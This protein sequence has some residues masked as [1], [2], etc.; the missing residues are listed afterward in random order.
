MRMLLLSRYDRLGASSRV[1]MFQYMPYLAA[2]G[3]TIDK[4]PLFSDAY[5]TALYA[6]GSR[7]AP[8]MRGYAR[9]LRALLR[10]RA[11]NLLWIEKELFPFLPPW[12]EHLLQRCGV[13]YVVD[14]DDAVF[15][16][17]DLHRLGLVRAALGHKIDR[18]MRDATVV[19]AGNEYL[20]ARARSAG[21]KRVEIVPTVVDL[22]RYTVPRRDAGTRMT[23]G[24]IGSPSTTRYLAACV[25]ALEAARQ[26]HDFRV[27]AVGANPDVLPGRLIETQPWSEETEVAAIQGFDVGIMPLPD[28]PWER[29][30]CGYKLIQ[31]MA[32]GVPVVA[33]PVGVNTAIVEPGVN[34]FLAN[35]ADEW[36]IAIDT[37]LGEPQRRLSMGAR[38]RER[39]EAQYSLQVQAPRLEAI[40]REAMR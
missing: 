5:V 2:Q 15:H 21:A 10:V 13:P 4:S 8:T 27:L 35:S 22:G 30:K 29:G 17:Y 36:R 3:W 18:V 39:I 6:R 33:S 9:R 37:L 12:A 1:R 40:L 34:G 32:C 20:A 24:W 23:V 7:I 31:Y 38:G 14:Y 28:D 26:K 11:Y 19:V 25:P 16:R